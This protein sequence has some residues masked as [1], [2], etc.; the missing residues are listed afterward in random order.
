M[1]RSSSGPGAEGCGDCDRSSVRL[2]YY[3]AFDPGGVMRRV[4]EAFGFFIVKI[5]RQAERMAAG[6]D[7]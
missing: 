1:T 3:A 5:A 2:I 4:A 7:E 6:V